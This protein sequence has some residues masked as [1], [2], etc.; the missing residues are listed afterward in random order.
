MI[1][2]RDQVN[3]VRRKISDHTFHGQ[4][5]EARAARQRAGKGRATAPP[6]SV[7]LKQACAHLE[8]RHGPVYAYELAVRI[9]QLSG[10]SR[11][12]NSCIRRDPELPS[13]EAHCHV[14][15]IWKPEHGT[16]E[17]AGKHCTTVAKEKPR[18][19]APAS[20]RLGVVVDG[21]EAAPVAGPRRR[22]AE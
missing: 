2:A 10:A 21:H 6:V 19:A 17:S 8:I 1:I 14:Q 16:I 4:R 20:E 12:D 22:T 18:Q 5:I 7:Y 15:Q 9:E 13:E 3:C 11:A